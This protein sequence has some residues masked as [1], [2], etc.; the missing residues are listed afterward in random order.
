MSITDFKKMN[1]SK[2]WELV[3]DRGAWCAAVHGMAKS[4]T[5]LSNWTELTEHLSHTRPFG[6]YLSLSWLPSSRYHNLLGERGEDTRENKNKQLQHIHLMKEIL[7]ANISSWNI[8]VINKKEIQDL[9]NVLWAA[10]I[11]GKATYLC[12]PLL[13]AV[14]SLHGYPRHTDKGGK[15]RDGVG[16]PEVT[17]G[18]HGAI[19]SYQ[20]IYQTWEQNSLDLATLFPSLRRW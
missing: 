1:L 10:A 7:P 17:L 15:A 2:L 8:S 5:Q 3:M 6:R 14:P 9:E 20:C 19:R 4:Q 12:Q 11:W 13:A 18:E 16:T